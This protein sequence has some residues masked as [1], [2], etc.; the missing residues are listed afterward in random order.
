MDRL[1]AMGVIET[2][3]AGMRPWTRS[4]CWRLLEEGELRVR[5]GAGGDEGELLYDELQREF[6]PDAGL[7]TGGKTTA[8]RS[9][10]STPGSPYFGPAAD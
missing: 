3:F 2:G 4:E 5:D 8:S 9:S 7:A 10:R 1:A 6:A